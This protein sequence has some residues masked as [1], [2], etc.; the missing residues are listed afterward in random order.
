MTQ[1]SAAGAK[2]APLVLLVAG[3]ASGDL[4][5]AE[6][7]GELRKLRPDVRVTGDL[8]HRDGRVREIGGDG[9]LHRMVAEMPLRKAFGYATQVRSITRGTASYS[10]R[11]LE[12]RAVQ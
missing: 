3:E 6:L 2:R 4:R 12:H 7:V 9:R 10:L 1:P 8:Q 5:G 11:Y